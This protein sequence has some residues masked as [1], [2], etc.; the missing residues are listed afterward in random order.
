[1]ISP[2][3]TYE[4]GKTQNCATPNRPSLHVTNDGGLTWQFQALSVTGSSLTCAS[5]YT[6]VLDAPDFLDRLHGFLMLSTQGGTTLL[7]TSDGGGSWSRR[8]MPGSLSDETSIGWLDARN[9]WAWTSSGPLI[10]TPTVPLYR[11]RDGGATWARVQANLRY[12]TADGSVNDIY[13]VDDKVGFAVRYTEAA[14]YN[15]LVRTTD[16]GLTWTEVGRLR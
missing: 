14:G 12:Q 1:M 6:C 11:T 16:G 10:P 7:A 4:L 9:G 5:L 2:D 3:R 13:F 8:S 15:W